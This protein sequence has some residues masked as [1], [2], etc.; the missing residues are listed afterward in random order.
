MS[1]GRA[2]VLIGMQSMA[3]AK[4]VAQLLRDLVDEGP[5]PDLGRDAE[6]A[7]SLAHE[8]RTFGSIDHA[9]VPRIV[10]EAVP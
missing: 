3:S 2:M 7:S 1:G 9:G 6:Y 8:L 4:R 5:A 10:I